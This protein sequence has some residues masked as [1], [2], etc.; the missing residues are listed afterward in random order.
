MTT[1]DAPDD[2]SKWFM[3]LDTAFA[4]QAATGIDAVYQLRFRDA[5]PYHLSIRTGGLSCG[6]GEHAA[7]TVTVF[8]DS[9]DNHTAVL[10]GRLDPMEAFLRGQF[11]A[12]GHIVLVMRMLQIFVP[13]YALTGPEQLH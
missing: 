12:D 6:N 4:A 13:Q 2:R 5:G 11:R 7:P 10:Q 8:F 9:F 1:Y 3:H